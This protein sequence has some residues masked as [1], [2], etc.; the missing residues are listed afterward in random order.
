MSKRAPSPA[1]GQRRPNRRRLRS[2]SL[3]ALVVMVSTNLVLA[4]LVQGLVR[5][6]ERGLLRERAGE[7]GFLVESR[8]ATVQARLELAGT[9]ALVSDRSPESFAA[10]PTP[11]DP[12]LL[13][14]ALLRPAPEGFVVELV[15][16]RF[17][18]P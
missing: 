15:A 10:V 1:S 5:D 2:L 11:P 17:M 16:G 4:W 6:Q 12:G 14:T 9:V 18:V 7:V 13:G 3:A 8:M